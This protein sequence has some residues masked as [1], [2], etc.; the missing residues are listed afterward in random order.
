M[1]KYIITLCMQK[2]T[3][4]P[5]YKKTLIKEFT[6]FHSIYIY[7]YINIYTAFSRLESKKVISDQKTSFK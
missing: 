4:L 7:L 6:R 2:Y 5:L 1:N 3:S